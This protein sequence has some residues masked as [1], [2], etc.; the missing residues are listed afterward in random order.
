MDE[1]S[2]ENCISFGKNQNF[3]LYIKINSMLNKELKYSIEIIKL[4]KENL[5]EF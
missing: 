1:W 3:A 4:L 2:W 5:G